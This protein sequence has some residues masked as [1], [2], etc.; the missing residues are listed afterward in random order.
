MTILILDESHEETAKFLDDKS[1]GKMIKS[2]AQV[3]CNAHWQNH[4]QLRDKELRPPLQREGFSVWTEWASLCIANYRYLVS[5]GLALCDEWIFR[6]MDEEDFNSDYE[7]HHIRN[8][9]S[10]RIKKLKRRA[11]GVMT[12]AGIG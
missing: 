1:L 6:F 10:V 11:L 9:R 8:L 5:L 7:A 3:L 12:A 4:L 2:V